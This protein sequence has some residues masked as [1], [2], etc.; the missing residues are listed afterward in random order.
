MF[1]LS[2]SPRVTVLLERLT[3]RV[4]VRAA[5][6]VGVVDVARV[7]NVE[8]VIEVIKAVYVLAVE[9]LAPLDPVVLEPSPITAIRL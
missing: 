6:V 7:V 9:L 3:I 8:G 1:L 5:D 4:G 2:S